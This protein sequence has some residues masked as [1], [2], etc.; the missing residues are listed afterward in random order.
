MSQGEIVYHVDRKGARRSGIY[1][2]LLALG[3]LVFLLLFGIVGV[4]PELS[5]VSRA[6][7][8]VAGAAGA[9]GFGTLGLTFFRRL[10]SGE[11]YLVIGPDGLHD[12]ASGLT[13]G[14]G[15]IAWSQI[16]DVRLSR[17]HNMDCV[18]LVPR[19][20]NDFM[21]RFGW[22]ERFNR[23]RRLGY[24]AVAIRGP[25]LPVEPAVLVEEIRRYWRGAGDG[26]P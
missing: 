15:W 25:L 19:D 4:A 20:R 6:V 16:G 21:R 9:L 24:P 23:S 13:S 7:A 11:P 1:F 17:Y 3:S 10:S 8:S 26:D 5:A 14:A 12:N 2:L 22:L 18:E